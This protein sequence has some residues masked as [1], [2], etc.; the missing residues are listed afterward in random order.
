MLD[1]LY[2]THIE[3]NDIEILLSKYKELKYKTEAYYYIYKIL[4]IKQMCTLFKVI[5][6]CT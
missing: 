1:M 6:Q 2:T 3:C 4:C 5:L